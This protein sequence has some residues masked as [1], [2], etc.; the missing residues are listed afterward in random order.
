M[1]GE[2]NTSRN[3]AWAAVVMAPAVVCAVSAGAGAGP[4]TITG[5]VCGTAAAALFAG[6]RLGSD[7]GA[8]GRAGAAVRAVGEAAGIVAPAADSA[9]EPWTREVVERV[10]AMRSGTAL[11][12]AITDA[13]DAPVFVTSTSGAIV[14]C[15]RA[16]C[17]FLE[18]RPDE[19]VGRELEDFF[20]Q[21][22]LLAAHDA[23]RDGGMHR[24]QVRIAREGVARTYQVLAGR[25][26]VRE[27]GGAGA[28]VVLTLRDITELSRAAQL[29]TDF[30]ANASHE[31]RTPL[32][33]IRGAVET[34]QELGEEDAEMRA[35]LVRMIASNAERLEDLTRDLLDLSRLESPEAP[36]E[37]GPVD[38]AE[39]VR[40]VAGLLEGSASRKRVTI[41]AE[42]EPGVA[43]L[44]SDPRL[45]RAILR[46]L[47]ENAVKFAYERTA[48]RVVAEAAGGEPA[49][50]D[51]GRSAEGEES[52]APGALGT[53]RLRVIDRGMG[54][55][56][57]QQ[58]RIF[59]RFY[60]GDPARTGDAQG[61]GT[62]LGLAIVKHAVRT[63]GG[64]IGVESVWK[65]GTTMTVELPGCVVGSP[66]AAADA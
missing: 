9:L 41:E 16:A 66:G 50:A 52:P 15:N 65:E 32:A 21:G 3:A 38:L 5:A 42:I 39:L 10:R 7:R 19:V 53:L 64:T 18:R 63:L 26:E 2:R 29:K 51:D 59:E 43:R 58:Q 40:A 34:L 47:I 33:S 14:F 1:T 20:S 8:S 35:R 11:R 12:E 46:N 48:V 28:V 23:A 36:A 27:G 17:E 54:I 62:G 45:L 25:A 56:L 13:T 44:E 24:G 6:W 37:I 22:E 61:R 49:G 30:V 55:P 57:A 31:L 4:W 60:Q